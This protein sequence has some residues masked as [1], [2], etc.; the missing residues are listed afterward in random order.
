MT[1]PFRVNQT[2]TV[3]RDDYEVLSIDGK[4]AELKNKS[5]GKVRKCKFFPELE[6]PHNAKY[7]WVD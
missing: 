5:S 7:E 6:Y 3:E 2:I 4:I 1:L